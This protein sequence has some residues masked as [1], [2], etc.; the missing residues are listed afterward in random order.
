MYTHEAGESIVLPYAFASYCTETFPGAFPV[1]RSRKLMFRLFRNRTKTNT[2]KA[3]STTEPTYSGK[4]IQ[5]ATSLLEHEL[6]R[7]FPIGI[8]LLVTAKGPKIS[9]G[10]NI[11]CL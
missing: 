7:A 4:C 5:F 10:M 8:G 2:C 3:I 9:L 1:S 11:S 6:E